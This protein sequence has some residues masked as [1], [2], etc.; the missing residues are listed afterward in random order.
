M[1][2]PKASSIGFQWERYEAWRHHPLL[3]VDKRNMV[4]G[5]GFGIALFI[6]VKAY[7]AATAIDDH[8]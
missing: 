2:L 1:V 6:A 5:L 4:P 3:K 8:H 7:E